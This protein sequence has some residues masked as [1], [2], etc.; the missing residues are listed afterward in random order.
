MKKIVAV[1]SFIYHLI[2]SAAFISNFIL[3]FDK[4]SFKKNSL[5]RY[6]KFF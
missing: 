1:L 2:F 5:S 4:N 3:I 6:W